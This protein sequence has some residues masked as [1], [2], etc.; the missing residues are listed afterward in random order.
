MRPTRSLRAHPRGSFA[1]AKGLNPDEGGADLAYYEADGDGGGAVFAAGSITW[2]SALCSSTTTCLGS[3]RTFSTAFWRTESR[4]A[5]TPPPTIPRAGPAD[6]DPAR[7]TPDERPLGCSPCSPSAAIVSYL[8]RASIS[9]AAT[10]IQADLKLDAVQMGYVLSGFF[11]G[12]IWL[13]IPGGWLGGR[14]GGPYHADSVRLALVVDDAR[15]G[16]GSVV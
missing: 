8:T 2:T 6:D 16:P 12:Y 9:T 4:A 11:M 13:Q 1:S 3:R 14:I 15:L 10:T 7:R 5:I